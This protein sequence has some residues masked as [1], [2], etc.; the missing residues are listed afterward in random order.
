MATSARRK[1]SEPESVTAR[2]VGATRDGTGAFARA[3][4][5]KLQRVS[6]KLKEWEPE[7]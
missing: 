1:P 3:G 4:P 2:I 7:D 5:M 6:S